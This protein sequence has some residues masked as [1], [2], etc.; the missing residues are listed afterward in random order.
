V[1]HRVAPCADFAAAVEKVLDKQASGEIRAVSAGC[2]PRE[3]LPQIGWL[4]PAIW[5]QDKGGWL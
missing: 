3:M 4:S 1:S 2:M 5:L